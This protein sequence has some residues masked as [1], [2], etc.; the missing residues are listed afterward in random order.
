MTSLGEIDLHLINEG[1]HERLWQVLGALVADH[2]T[3]FRVWAPN[4]IEVQ[5]LGDFN[6]WSG[7]HTPMVRVGDSGVWEASVPGLGSGEKYQFQIR[8]ADGSW[9][10]KADPMAGW[11]EIP[12]QTASRTF[13]STHQWSDQ[14]WMAERSLVSRPDQEPISVYEVHLA[15]W[16][17]GLDYDQL[18]ATLPGYVNDLGF[19]HVE[20][21]P[22]ME[23][24]YGG[25]WGYQVTSYYAP[26][27][28]LG[29]PDGFRRLVDA[30]HRAGIGVILDWVPAHF[31]RDEFAL[32]CF[33][34]TALYEDPNPQR[35]EHPDWGTLIFNYGRHEVRNFLVANA[36]YWL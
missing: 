12:P 19:T 20:F 24:P 28:R 11:A 27:A 21:L 22:V 23:H 34:G 14:D 10:A 16:R 17:R 1:R 13:R 3:T 35:G 15:S 6:D 36:L 29:D 9:R 32:S 33:D 8:G 18:A 5:V 31:P 4:A 25:S 30:L 7:A 26:T 2:G